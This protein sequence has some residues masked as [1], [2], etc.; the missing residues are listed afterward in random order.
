MCGGDRA[1][2]DVLVPRT[3]GRGKQAL[4]ESSSHL[5]LNVLTP[6]LSFPPLF[7]SSHSSISILSTKKFFWNLAPQSVG[8][9]CW[10]IVVISICVV[11]LLPVSPSVSQTTRP[12]GTGAI[13]NL[14]KCALGPFAFMLT[15]PLCNCNFLQN[16]Q[17]HETKKSNSKTK[18]PEMVKC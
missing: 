7:S 12:K 3:R 10:K 15:V 1:R 5:H 18:T 14:F 9:A 6:R 17:Q 2:A 16:E 4:Q 11:V 13:S 8:K